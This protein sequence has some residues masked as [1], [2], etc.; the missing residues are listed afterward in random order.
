MHAKMYVEKGME[1]IGKMHG[2]MGRDKWELMR[3]ELKERATEEGV[4]EEGE[5]RKIVCERYKV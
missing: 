5:F 1:V 4:L 3:E 2:K